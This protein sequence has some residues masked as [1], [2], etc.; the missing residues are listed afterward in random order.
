ME[1]LFCAVV[2]STSTGTG[3]QSLTMGVEMLL[4]RAQLGWRD[5]GLCGSWRGETA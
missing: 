3:E 1:P 4:V 2:F 5:I